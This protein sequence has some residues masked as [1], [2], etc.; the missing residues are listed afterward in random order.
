MHA[1]AP[2]ILI[3][4]VND[5][6]FR[7]FY[8][9]K[10]INICH[11]IENLMAGLSHLHASAPWIFFGSIVRLRFLSVYG[12]SFRVASA[13]SSKT[14]AEGIHLAIWDTQFLLKLISVFL[15]RYLF[16]VIVLLL[17]KNIMKEPE[18][19]V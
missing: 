17:Y 10:P 19:N 6:H 4:P 5:R 7:A 1:S 16:Y 2:W 3:L 13:S 9:L 18:E 11:K 8:A 12:S 14:C 15:N